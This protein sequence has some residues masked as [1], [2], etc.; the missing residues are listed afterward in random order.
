MA[1][2]QL[3]LLLADDPR[4]Q[5]IAHAPKVKARDQDLPLHPERLRRIMDRLHVAAVA[6]DHNEPRQTMPH[7]AAEH[8]RQHRAQGGLVQRNPARHRAE[9]VRAAERQGRGGQKSPRRVRRR[10]AR[11]VRPARRPRGSRPSAHAA[12][13]PRGSPSAAA[14]PDCACRPR[15]PRRPSARPC[16]PWC[17]RRWSCHPLAPRSPRSSTH[18]ARGDKAGDYSVS[19]SRRPASRSRSVPR[20]GNSCRPGSCPPAGTGTGRNAEPTT[21]SKQSSQSPWLTTASDGPPRR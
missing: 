3:R 13:G 15:A 12:P 20:P 10:A 9:I 6:V 7:Q 4:Q 21:R 2:D 5:S 16:G 18:R 14:A 11:S 17:G 1:R 19:R 8:V